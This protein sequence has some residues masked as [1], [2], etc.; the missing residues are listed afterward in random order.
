MRI[1]TAEQLSEADKI[2]IKKQQISSEELMEKAASLVFK[3]IHN[4]LQT[5]QIPIK[6]FCGIGN[7]GGDGLVVARLLMEQAYSVEVFIV[8]YSDKR[9]EDFLSNFQKLKNLDRVR[10]VLINSETDFPEIKSGDFIIDAIFGI[11]LNRPAE[12]WVAKLIDRLN[13]SGAFKLSIDMPSGLFSD[14]PTDPDSSIIHADFT[15]SFQTP[16]MSF[17]LPES[18]DYVGDFQI[19][20]IGLDKEYLAKLKPQA[21]LVSKG[22]AQSLYKPRRKNSHKGDYGHLLI[23]G[24]SYGKMGSVNLTATAA[25]RTG[26]GLCTLYIPR[27]GYEI[28]Q[29]NLPEA[30]VL[31]GDDQD[32]LSGYPEDFEPDGLCFGMGAGTSDKAKTALEDMLKRTK[33]PVLVDA[34]GLNILSENKELLKLLPENSVLTPHPGELKRLIGQ[35]TDDFEKLEKVK[36]FSQKYKIIVLVKGAYTFIVNREEVYINNSGNPG[37]ATAGSGDVLSGVIASLMVQGYSPLSAAVLGVYQ[38]GV[39]G[40]IAASEKGYEAIM[41]SDIAANMGIAFLRLTESDEA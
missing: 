11:G 32:F 30:M 12:G 18:M 36:K 37:M 28:L 35:W 2:S 15:L 20:D 9:S 24:G 3:E 21:V 4:R 7:N 27:C 10:P 17:F 1:L 6:I 13:E 39:S 23:S 38:H 26:C 22:I 40:D 41:A 33:K 29:T 8:N 5:A 31:T 16:K 19:L 34:D 25:L 14:K